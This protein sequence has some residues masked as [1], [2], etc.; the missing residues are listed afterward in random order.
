M[1]VAKTAVLVFINISQ[2][3]PNRYALCAI[4]KKGRSAIGAGR[5]AVLVS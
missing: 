4:R 2:G 3:R 1:P 5:I